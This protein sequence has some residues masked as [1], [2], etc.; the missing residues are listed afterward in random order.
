MKKTP[1]LNGGVYNF[2][3]GYKTFDTSDTINI[4]KYLMK[5]II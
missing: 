3:V 1:G 4:H 2:S 5:N